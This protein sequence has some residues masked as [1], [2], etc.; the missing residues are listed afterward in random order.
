MCSFLSLFSTL[1]AYGFARLGIGYWIF[2]SDVAAASPPNIQYLLPHNHQFQIQQ[3]CQFLDFPQLL[4]HP[5]RTVMGGPG[6][7]PA[8]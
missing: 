4:P 2:G 5:Q 3:P 6:F 1:F 7:G 8:A